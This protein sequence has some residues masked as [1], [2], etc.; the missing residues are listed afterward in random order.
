MASVSQGQIPVGNTP[1]SVANI[2]TTLRTTPPAGQTAKSTRSAKQAVPLNFQ[3][4]VLTGAGALAEEQRSR[5]QASSPQSALA[6][7][8]NPAAQAVQSLMSPPASSVCKASEAPASTPVIN[9][10]SPDQA[11]A[12]TAEPM[13]I[14]PQSRPS[15]ARPNH[16]SVTDPRLTAQ[17][18]NSAGLLSVP[19][20][21]AEE[22]ANKALSYPPRAD[23]IERSDTPS[24]S[25]TMPDPSSKSKEPKK[26]RCDHCGTEFTRHHNLKS[27]LLTHSHEKPYNCT[28]CDQRFR[29][30]HD[31]KRHTKLHT[32]EKPHTCNKCGRPFARGDALARH[33]KG[34]GGCAGRRGSAGEDDFDDEGMDGIEYDESGEHVAKRRKSEQNLQ[35]SRKRSINT[36]GEPHLKQMSM[37]YPQPGVAPM[38]SNPPS[39]HANAPISHTHLSPCMAST[40]SHFPSQQMHNA[41]S[42]FAQGGITESPKPLSPGQEQTRRLSAGL[43]VPGRG[44]SPSLAQ[45]Q[46]LP[47]GG[48]LSSPSAP[49]LQGPGGH[50]NLPSLDSVT[51]NRTSSSMHSSSTSSAPK[52]SRPPPIISTAQA[53]NQ[54]GPSPSS[55]NPPSATSQNRGSGGSLREIVNPAIGDDY[56]SKA[57]HEVSMRRVQDENNARFAELQAQIRQLQAENQ[58]LKTIPSRASYPTPQGPGAT[59]IAGQQ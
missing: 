2:K 4:P 53:F 59:E 43:P 26:H 24:R 41:Q 45:Q 13:Q 27:H 22:R 7:S 20:G 10:A 21:H 29:R 51:S 37:T 33:N 9:G 39:A 40:S 3:A 46:H 8:P 5:E 32:G 42:V 30:L 57:D 14:D 12:I 28:R 56:I 44:R 55:T 47:R 23:Q 36:S 48:T 18:A 19:Q 35:H 6:T 1:P 50:T 17:D 49:S 58:A 16:E 11:G 38:A 34:P 15:T 25:M 31:L 54:P 52:N